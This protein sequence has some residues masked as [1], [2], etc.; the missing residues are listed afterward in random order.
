MAKNRQSRQAIAEETVR[1]IEEKGY[2]IN[3]EV[4]QELDQASKSWIT[5]D[6]KKS[7]AGRF[8][9]PIGPKPM[10]LALLGNSGPT[11]PDRSRFRLLFCLQTH[12]PQGGVR[13]PA[14]IFLRSKR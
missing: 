8:R 2:Y 4:Q 10:G 3:D 9:L 7:A 11:G 6:R 5:L 13:R 14:D 12:M 1:I